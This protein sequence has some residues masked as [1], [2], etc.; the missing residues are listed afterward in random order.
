MRSLLVTNLSKFS[1]FKCSKALTVVNK[2]QCELE[3]ENCPNHLNIATYTYRTT[4]GRYLPGFQLLL[5]LLPDALEAE[6]PSHSNQPCLVQPKIKFNKLRI[7]KNFLKIRF[8]WWGWIVRLNF[9]VFI[10]FCFN[11]LRLE[12]IKSVK[13][14]EQKDAPFELVLFIRYF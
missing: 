6:S 13:K 12:W 10:L 3:W 8:F 4:I 2:Y 11:R 14:T 5:Q 9:P 1:F 7:K